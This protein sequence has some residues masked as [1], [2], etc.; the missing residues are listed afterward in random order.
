MTKAKWIIGEKITA[1]LIVTL[2]L[3]AG[4]AV[5]WGA[6]QEAGRNQNAI[7][8]TQSEKRIQRQWDSIQKA[9]DAISASY[10]RIA[11]LESQN[12]HLSKQLDAVLSNMID[13]GKFK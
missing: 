12:K 6:K 4:I 10:E 13:H 1:Q 7:Q 2:I 9:R 8:I 5:W 3:Y 11:A